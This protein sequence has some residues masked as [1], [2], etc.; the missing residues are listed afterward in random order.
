MNLEL[1]EQVSTALLAEKS[2]NNFNIM[3]KYKPQN[4]EINLLYQSLNG[5]IR[6][7]KVSRDSLY[8]GKDT[9]ALKSYH[10]AV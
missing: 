10:Q 3:L 2:E 1:V 4:Y 7:V 5:L 9:K 6:T 8:L